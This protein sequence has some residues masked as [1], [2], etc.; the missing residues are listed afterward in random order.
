MVFST[1]TWFFYYCLLNCSGGLLLWKPMQKLL[2]AVLPIRRDVVLLNV[3][4]QVTIDSTFLLN[5]VSRIITLLFYI[6][7][8]RHHLFTCAFS[9]Q[10]I[11]SVLFY[12]LCLA[13]P[14]IILCHL[15]ISSCQF[16]FQFASDHSISIF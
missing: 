16:I 15:H 2:C 11:P 13:S 3:L 1:E 4:Q 8:Y 5:S 14:N 9:I 6:F 12:P 7:N 10:P